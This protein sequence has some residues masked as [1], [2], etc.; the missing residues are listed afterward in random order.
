MSNSPETTQ[1]NDRSALMFSVTP[2]SKPAP[3]VVYS[4]GDYCT[5]RA[6]RKYLIN[7][8]VVLLYDAKVQV[9]FF[10]SINNLFLFL[11]NSSSTIGDLLC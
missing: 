2:A 1:S 11:L 10:S 5:V 4:L 3:W 8:L 7:Q 6:A 9:D